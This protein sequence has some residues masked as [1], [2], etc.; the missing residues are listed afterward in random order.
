MTK[1]GVACM[2]W[3]HDI[4]A[5]LRLLICEDRRLILEKGRTD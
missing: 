5:C 2:L 3:I 4:Q 1:E